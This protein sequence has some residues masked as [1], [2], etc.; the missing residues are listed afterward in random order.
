MS[1]ICRVKVFIYYNDTSHD[2]SHSS[3]CVCTEYIVRVCVVVVCVYVVVCGCMCA[4]TRENIKYIYNFNF[5]GDIM[6]RI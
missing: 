3:Y 5:N 2:T 4:C 6:T 1:F